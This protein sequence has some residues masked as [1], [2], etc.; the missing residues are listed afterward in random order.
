MKTKNRH[1]WYSNYRGRFSSGCGAVNMLSC[2]GNTGKKVTSSSSEESPRT[3]GRKQKKTVFT[4]A[5]QTIVIHR[6]Q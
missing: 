3:E 2:N 1:K 6:H 5:L 4:I